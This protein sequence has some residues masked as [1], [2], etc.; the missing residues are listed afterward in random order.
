MDRDGSRP[1]GETFSGSCMDAAGRFWPRRR[2]FVTGCT[3]HLGGPAVQ[4]L[5]A[6][7][8]DVACLVREQPGPGF[9]FEHK[10]HLKVRVVRGRIEDRPRLE[11]ALAI[12]DPA[13][14]LH[15]AKPRAESP[16]ETNGTFAWTLLA[17]ARIAAPA[18]T[19]VFPSPLD[20][21]RQDDVVD[22]FRTTTTN[23][24]GVARLPA[25]GTT[26]TAAEA[27]AF[28]LSLAER[29]ATGPTAG[30]LTL[31]WPGSAAKAAA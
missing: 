16:H 19:V 22:G 21:T 24:L 17:A 30:R 11:T 25:V 10:L 26:P 6:A 12:Y 4:A 18:A 28:L 27:A 23:P 29:L 13:V 1:R 9:F 14:I 8:A 15:L 3:G 2:V 20:R 31:T 5:V 7:G